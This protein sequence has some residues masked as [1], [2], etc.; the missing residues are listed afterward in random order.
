[1]YLDMEKIDTYILYVVAN[2][3]SAT[4]GLVGNF[5]PLSLI[6]YRSVASI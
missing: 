3:T 4:L 6:A 5:Q 1:M 2:I